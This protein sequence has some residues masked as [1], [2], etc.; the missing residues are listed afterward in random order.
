[1]YVVFSSMYIRHGHSLFAPPTHDYSNRKHPSKCYVK[2]LWV[3][4][5]VKT[6]LLKLHIIQPAVSQLPRYK[7]K[8]KKFVISAVNYSVVRMRKT[9]KFVNLVTSARYIKT[10]DF[11]QF[12]LAPS[13][14]NRS[15]T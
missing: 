4:I 11:R 12:I 14:L 6:K 5:R 7:I 3:D 9:P 8:I 13:F 1:M 2:P 15:N 10:N